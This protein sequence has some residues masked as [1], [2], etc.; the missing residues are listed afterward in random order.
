MKNS[1]AFMNS[2]RTALQRTLAF[3]AGRNTAVIAYKRSDNP[4]AEKL[5][6]EF[7]SACAR[8]ELGYM[9]RHLGRPARV[10][11]GEPLIVITLLL[12]NDGEDYVDDQ[13][14]PAGVIPDKYD[15]V[16]DRLQL[17][18]NVEYTCVA[19]AVAAFRTVC[20]EM[21]INHDKG[22]Q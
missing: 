21:I 1:I 6:R 17:I 15:I 18:V 3:I 2:C 4:Q 13:I 16:G 14:L 11:Q 10:H 7:T 22:V 5:A 8:G 19:E 12:N 20:A 9:V